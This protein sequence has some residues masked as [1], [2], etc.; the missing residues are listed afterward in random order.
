MKN[1][2]ELRDRVATVFKRM[3]EGVIGAS[4]AA[5]YVSLANVMVATAMAQVQYQKDRAKIPH[6]EFLE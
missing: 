6:V 4:E 5:S 1:V 3:E 2:A